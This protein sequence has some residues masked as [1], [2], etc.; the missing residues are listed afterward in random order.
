MAKTNFHINIFFFHFITLLW[1]SD[2]I[3]HERREYGAM[4][5]GSSVSS[6]LRARCVMHLIRLNV[7]ASSASFHSRC[8]ISYA[9]SKNV[10]EST[11]RESIVWDVKQLRD[12]GSVLMLSAQSTYIIK[13]WFVCDVSKYV[14]SVIQ[15]HR[16]QC[17]RWRCIRVLPASPH[18]RHAAIYLMNMHNFSLLLFYFARHL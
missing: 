1:P 14:A 7:G 17:E 4:A 11:R 3:V 10:I 13:L 16:F 15:T 12:V 8:R 2:F 9:N 6:V 5:F 18:N